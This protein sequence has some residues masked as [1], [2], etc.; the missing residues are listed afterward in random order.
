MVGMNA[1]I[2]LINV[3]YLVRMRQAYL[4]NEARASA[5]PENAV[6]AAAEHNA[7]TDA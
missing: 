7:R 1:T 6:P 2:A 4:A 5:E 3:Y